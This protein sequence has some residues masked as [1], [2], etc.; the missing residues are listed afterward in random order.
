MADGPLMCV[1]WKAGSD[2]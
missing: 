1:L 2:Q